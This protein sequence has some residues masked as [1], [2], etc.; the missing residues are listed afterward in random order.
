MTPCPPQPPGDTDAADFPAAANDAS[1]SACA[2]LQEVLQG[3]LSSHEQQ[4]HLDAAEALG[5][6]TVQ[7]LMRALR[8]G[9]YS[10]LEQHLLLPAKAHAHVVAKLVFSASPLLQYLLVNWSFV[11]SHVRELV[12]EYE[13]FQSCADKTHT[14]MKT[15]A[16]HLAEGEPYAFNREQPYT[17]HLPTRVLLTQEDALTFLGALMRLS[18]GQVAPY[19]RWLRNFLARQ[20][21]A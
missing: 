18:R 6:D 12:E 11:R 4:Q 8:E 13:G 16:R 7:A 17:Y 10:E 9:R 1:A 21:Q 3:V 20:A 5:Q 2:T 14:I 15:L 19:V